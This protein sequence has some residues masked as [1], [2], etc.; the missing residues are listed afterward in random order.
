MDNRKKEEQFLEN[1][2]FIEEENNALDED[3]VSDEDES[4]IE[5]LDP[6]APDEEL[7]HIMDVEDE[8]A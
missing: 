1:I 4:K 8:H 7:E 6:G 3:I 2:Q 5:R